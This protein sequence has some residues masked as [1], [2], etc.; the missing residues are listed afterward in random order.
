MK[1]IILIAVLVMVACSSAK[2]QTNA[3]KYKIIYCDTM[4][5]I[6]ATYNA[7]AVPKK[8][9]RIYLSDNRYKILSIDYTGYKHGHLKEVAVY[10]VLI[11]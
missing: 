6:L 11:N 9:Q 10:L 5:H 7:V 1:Y 8:T 2:A 3:Y 4:G